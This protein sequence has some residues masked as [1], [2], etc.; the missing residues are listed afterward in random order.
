[1]DD[2]GQSAQVDAARAVIQKAG[3][4]FLPQVVQRERWYGCLKQPTGSSIRI[5]C[6]PS[7]RLTWHTP[8]FQLQHP[9]DN[10]TRDEK[11]P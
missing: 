2:P 1:V 10:G 3:A 6:A 9:D 7:W 5:F 8:V 11:F 4:V